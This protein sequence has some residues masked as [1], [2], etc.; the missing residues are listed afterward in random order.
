MTAVC[1]CDFGKGLAT[2]HCAACHETFTAVGPFDRHQRHG[3]PAGT[4]CLDPATATRRDGRPVF[5]A[6]RKTPG[7]R[8]VW[9]MASE[10]PHPRARRGGS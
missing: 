5:A 8:P 6:Y 4:V 7:G 10:R 2:C 3:G 1:S 9:G